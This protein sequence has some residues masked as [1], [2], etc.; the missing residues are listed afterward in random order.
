V[1]VLR[2]VMKAISWSLTP[3]GSEPVCDLVILMYHRV[4]GDI[5]LEI[6]V[7][8]AHFAAQMRWLATRG[9]VVSL[10][11]GLRLVQGPNEL[12]DERRRFVI[13]FDD[14]YED[15]YTRAFP[16]LVEL[17]LP[18]TLYV[19]TGFLNDPDTPPISRSV[20]NGDRLQPMRWWMLEEVARSRL[21]TIGSHT[22]SHA[23]L[24]SLSDRQINE[25]LTRCDDLLK[26]RLGVLPQHFAY[27]RGAWDRRVELVIRRRYRSAA[28]VGGG[29]ISLSG[30][31]PFRLSRIPVLRSDGMR[32]FESRIKGRL[33]Y[34]EEM[35]RA[36][37]HFA[38][39]RGRSFGY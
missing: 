1:V 8:Y 30:L 37:K 4:T 20:R 23:E 39:Q 2:N 9:R 11:E 32:W 10:A 21:M 33:Q 17:D 27:P 36:I 3:F 22:H 13:T 34:E 28:L 24:P 31:D 35:V 29:A 12:Q 14:A 6:D 15:F 16:L 18:A 19:P 25:E 38:R 7:K 5:P 26:E